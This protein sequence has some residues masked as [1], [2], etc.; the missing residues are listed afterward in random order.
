VPADVVRAG[1]LGG[2]AVRSALITLPLGLLA[3]STPATSEAVDKFVHG[4]KLARALLDLVAGLPA[5]YD[6]CGPA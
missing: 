6:G 2:L 1:Y 5:A 4:L 3:G